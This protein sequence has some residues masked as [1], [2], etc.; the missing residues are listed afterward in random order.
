[1][2]QQFDIE[3]IASQTP[4][5]T[6]NLSQIETY[7]DHLEPMLDQIHGRLD[8]V[9]H[10]D[11]CSKW[12]A[13][14][15]L[16]FSTEAKKSTK[17]FEDLRMYLN[18]PA[19][20]YQATINERM[21]K[22]TAPLKDTVEAV[23]EKIDQFEEKVKKEQ[24]KAQEEALKM[25]VDMGLNEVPYVANPQQIRSESATVYKKKSWSFKMN[26]LK[27]VP[28]EYL[29]VDQ[30]KVEIAVRNGVRNIPGLEIYET[31]K[32]IIKSRY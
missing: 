30:E 10:F 9:R 23:K 18:E 20:K 26:D 7:L 5:Y 22:F 12:A 32:T 11:V 31:E 17:Q 28:L 27:K 13:D 15:I 16:S 24:I 14:E 8:E 3:T 25:A 6:S 2:T 29:Q 4:Q 21:R 19:K 1:M